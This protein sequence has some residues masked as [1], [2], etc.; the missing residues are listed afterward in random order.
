[1][2]GISKASRH[3]SIADMILHASFRPQN[4]AAPRENGQSENVQR[5]TKPVDVAVNKELGRGD[6]LQ[7][8]HTL[9]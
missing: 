3:S 2:I 4:G 6:R 8:R 9:V 1:M 7:R 5:P